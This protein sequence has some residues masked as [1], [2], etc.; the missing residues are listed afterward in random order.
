MKQYGVRRNPLDE[1]LKTVIRLRHSG[2]YFCAGTKSPTNPI[3]QAFGLSGNG[4]GRRT[5]K[6]ATLLFGNSRASFE[7]NKVTRGLATLSW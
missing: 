7:L 6:R 2:W 1:V 5:L 4:N 3:S